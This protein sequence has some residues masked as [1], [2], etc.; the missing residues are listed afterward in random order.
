MDDARYA[1]NKGRDSTVAVAV[2]A[3]TILLLIIVARFLPVALTAD[4]MPHRNAILPY[5]LWNLMLA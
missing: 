2:T 4:K 1:M 5:F 3:W